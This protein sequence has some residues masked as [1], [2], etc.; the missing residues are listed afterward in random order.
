MGERQLNPKETAAFDQLEVRLFGFEN[1][2]RFLLGTG[3]LF[4]QIKLSYYRTNLKALRERASPALHIL[5][6]TIGS[7]FGAT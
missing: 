1:Y 7:E 3:W 2:G 4:H 6:I 5:I